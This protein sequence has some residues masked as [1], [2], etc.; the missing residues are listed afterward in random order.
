MA[1]Y[2][3]IFGILLLLCNGCTHTAHEGATVVTS[4]AQTDSLTA[5]IKKIAEPI[6]LPRYMG[7]CGDRLFIYKEK[8]E[9]MFELFSLPEAEFTGC[10]GTRGQGPDEW[11]SLID[12]RSFCLTDTAFS[13]IDASVSLLKT[14]VWTDSAF[15]VSHQ[16]RVRETG[17]P[18]Q[19]FYPVNDGRY[20]T[21][22]SLAAP[23]EL[24]LFDSTNE[25]IKSTDFPQWTDLND[26]DNPLAPAFAYAKTCVVSP[27][28][29]RIAAFYSYFKRMRIYDEHLNLL[30]DVDIQIKPFHTHFSPAGHVAQQPQY[31]IGQPQ[32]VNGCIYA[33]CSNAAGGEEEKRSELHIFDWN[34]K[35]LACYT[36]DRRLSL[37]AISGRHRKIYAL[38][39]AVE[40]ELYI[41]ELPAL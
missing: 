3:S 14:A 17:Q 34:G 12:P 39:K 30:Q 40:D 19:G 10:S 25:V 20:V 31:Y 33:L 41:Y 2:L 24:C 6:L 22:G 32:A 23:Q 13:A 7:I 38:N 4:F 5:E 15:T 16:R 9:F 21:L 28:R 27:D 37:I 35:A 29:K 1:R 36:F 26:E 11:V 8:E 18:Y